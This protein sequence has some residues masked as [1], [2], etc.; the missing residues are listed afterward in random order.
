M[1][2]DTS[3]KSFTERIQRGSVRTSRL[4]VVV[5]SERDEVG[6]KE[7]RRKKKEQRLNW[8]TDKGASLVGALLCYKGTSVGALPVSMWHGP[9][10][11]WIPRAPPSLVPFYTPRAPGWLVPCAKV[12]IW[13]KF[14]RMSISEKC[15]IEGPK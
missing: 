5:H 4:S 3:R 2:E 8:Y 10:S 6:K 11:S 15:F 7:R 14:P 9:R 1:G 12:Q 13:K